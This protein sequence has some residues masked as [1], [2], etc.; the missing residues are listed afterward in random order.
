MQQQSAFLT[1]GLTLSATAVRFASGTGWLPC[2]EHAPRG[3]DCCTL[4]ATL[5][6]KAPWQRPETI[7]V[8]FLRE[9]FLFSF[10][11]YGFYD[12]SVDAFHVNKDISV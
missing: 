7:V 12:I 2:E 10:D 4:T 8:H 5:H 6:C 11:L 1:T 3:C 9:M